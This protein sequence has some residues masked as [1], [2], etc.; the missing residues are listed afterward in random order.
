MK[1]E[2]KVTE[3]YPSKFGITEFAV[4]ATTLDTVKVLLQ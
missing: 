2:K 3:F 4:L 1:K